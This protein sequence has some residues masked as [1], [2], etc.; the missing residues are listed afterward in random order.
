MFEGKDR[1]RGDA[2]RQAVHE[3]TSPGFGQLCGKDEDPIAAAIRRAQT[4]YFVREDFDFTRPAPRVS[5]GPSA[6]LGSTDPL[7]D[8]RDC[9]RLPLQP[10][11]ASTLRALDQILGSLRS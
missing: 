11:P 4:V 10:S 7:T 6:E 3:Q 8:L 5:L 1:E 9:A 2:E